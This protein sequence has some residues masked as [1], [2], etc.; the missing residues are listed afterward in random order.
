[1]MQDLA[2]F[3]NSK[4]NKIIFLL[5]VIVSVI[6]GLGSTID[7]YRFAVVGA[8]FEMLWLLV[9][10]SIPVLII[11]AARYW[12]KDKLNSRSLNLYSLLLVIITILFTIFK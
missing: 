1:M 3:N 9:I 7:I 5:S 10:I 12:I 8:I 4:T 6:W 11:L 2:V